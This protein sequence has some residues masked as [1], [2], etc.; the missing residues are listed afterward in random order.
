MTNIFRIRT[1][2]YIGVVMTFSILSFYLGSYVQDNKKPDKLVVDFK[3]KK[4]ELTEYNLNFISP[5]GLHY[6]YINES[7]NSQNYKAYFDTLR[8]FRENL[9][10]FNVS[11]TNYLMIFKPD[12]T[13]NLDDEI[14]G[15]T[16]D[17]FFIYEP[18]EI[19]LKNFPSFSMRRDGEN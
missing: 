16:K 5:V 15:F 2:I 9:V 1:W 3:T 4:G 19:I 12:S 6:L 17:K 18:K 14:Y 10:Y 7:K 8:Y 13:A 11:D